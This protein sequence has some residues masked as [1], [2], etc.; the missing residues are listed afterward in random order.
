MSRAMALLAF[1]LSAA[2]AAGYLALAASASPV[3]GAPPLAG[4]AFSSPDGDVR[5]V[6]RSLE[7]ASENGAPLT[8]VCTV[9]VAGVPLSVTV[10]FENPDREAFARC[11]AA[12]GGRSAPCQPA[13]YVVQSPAFARI[14]S[15]ELGLTAQ[16]VAEVQA[17]Y[18][19]SRLPEGGWTW[20]GA[21][22]ALV[23]AVGMGLGVAGWIHQPLFSRRYWITAGL[24]ALALFFALTIGLMTAISGLALID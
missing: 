20:L 17:R 2:M 7:C 21:A 12:Y 8:A 24:T 23:S 6:G 13:Q 14:E 9:M 10:V 1:A 5:V 11:R 22:I 16:A 19:A 15:A 18:P 3:F 4:I